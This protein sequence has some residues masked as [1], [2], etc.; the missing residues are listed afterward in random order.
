MHL[1]LVWCI[2]CSQGTAIGGNIFISRASW[3]TRSSR[4]VLYNSGVL[5]KHNITW[6]PYQHHAEGFLGPK[7]PCAVLFSPEPL[8]TPNL[9]TSCIFPF[10]KVLDPWDHTE[11][12][13]S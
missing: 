4:C 3:F 10:S 13:L 7:I 2:C 8:A 11:C 5:T 6:P 9:F 12:S 1:A